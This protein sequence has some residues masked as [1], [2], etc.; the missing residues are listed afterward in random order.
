MDPILLTPKHA[1]RQHD[2]RLRSA[3]DSRRI[4]EF[5]R[6]LRIRGL[7]RRAILEAV[8]LDGDTEGLVRE[9]SGLVRSAERRLSGRPCC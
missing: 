5:T 8:R 7:L 6:R 3:E 4:Q 2:Q 1:L 9:V